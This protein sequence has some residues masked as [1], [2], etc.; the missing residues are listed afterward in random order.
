MAFL[1]MASYSYGDH[2]GQEGDLMKQYK[3]VRVKVSL[4][5]IGLGRYDE[6]EAVMNDMAKD[7]WEV[8]CTTPQ[9]GTP[10]TYMLVTFGRDETDTTRST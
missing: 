3:I 7:G 9:P 5:D 8:V 1:L 10:S 6:V 2:H 4:E